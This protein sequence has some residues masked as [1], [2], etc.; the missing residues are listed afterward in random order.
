[1]FNMVLADNREGGMLFT[2]GP[3]VT[4]TQEDSRIRGIIYVLQQYMWQFVCMKIL[5][6]Y[7]IIFH[8]SICHFQAPK[9][10]IA[11]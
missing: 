9:G 2:A 3:N 1:M 6:L 5:S 10:P 8:G 11:K 4:H 7:C